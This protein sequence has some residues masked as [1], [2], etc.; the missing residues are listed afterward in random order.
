MALLQRDFVVSS[1]EYRHVSTKVINVSRAMKAGSEAVFKTLRISSRM[2]CHHCGCQPGP[3]FV[4]VE[5][6]ELQL[7]G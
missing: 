6:K 5:I 7:V 3:K 1:K 2:Q 4:Q